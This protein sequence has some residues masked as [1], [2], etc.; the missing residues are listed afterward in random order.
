MGKNT[1]SMH[2]EKFY[3]LHT[4]TMIA[5]ATSKQ[6]RETDPSEIARTYNII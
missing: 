6:S 3:Q 2:G 1:K 4:E 5:V